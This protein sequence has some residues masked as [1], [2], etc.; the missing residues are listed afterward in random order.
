MVYFNSNP[1]FML[2]IYIGG[3]DVLLEEETRLP[4]EKHQK[5]LTSYHIMLHRVHLVWT[6]F[7]LISGDKHRLHRY[8]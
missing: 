2:S 6:R 8:M 1:N 3:Y 7:E 5:S 4:G